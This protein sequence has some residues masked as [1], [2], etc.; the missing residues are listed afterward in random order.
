MKRIIAWLLVLLLLF[1]AAAAEEKSEEAPANRLT[2]GNPTPMRG[3]FFTSLWGNSTSDSDVRDLLHGYNLVIWDGDLG[4]FKTDPTVV[5]RISSRDEANGNRIYTVEL[6]HDLTYSD[7]T[8]ITAKDYAFTY[9]FTLSKEAAEIGA[10]ARR[11]DQFLGYEEYMSGEVPYL[12]GVQLINDYTL[13]ITILKTY[14]P[15]F[16]EYGLLLCN[17][18]P[19]SVIAPGVIVK[20]DGEGVYL[21]NEDEQVKDPIFTADLLRKTV[22][23]PETGY[24]SHP[25][26]VSG[27]YML[28]SWDGVTAEFEVNPYYKGNSEGIRPTIPSLVYT[29][30]NND[31]QVED[32]QSGT[33][34]LLNKVAR[35][36]VIDKGIQLTTS[37]N[38]A[39]ETY[40]RSGLCFL[41]FACEKSTVSSTAVRQAIAWCLDRDQLTSDYIGDYGVT[42]D[43]Y[44][45]IGQYMYRLV[46]GEAE[47]PVEDPE[48][49][50]SQREETYYQERIEAF[51]KLNLNGLTHY[52]V[53]T[54]KASQLLERDGWR[55][56]GDGLRE[57]NGVVLDLKMICPEGNN[58]T[59]YLEENFLKNL[60]TV[61]IRL[62]VEVVP[63]NQL[64]SY[65]YQQEERTADL[66]LLAS[67]FD[68]L[69]DPY[70]YF[71]KDGNWAYT[72]LQ[73]RALRFFAKSMITAEPGD[74]LTYMQNWVAFQERF[75]EILP[76]I[77]IYS[78]Y[79]YDFFTNALKNYEISENTTWSEA[80]VPA[81]LQ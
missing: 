66:I 18:Y 69:F 74:A 52:T 75:N 81:T 48:T 10:V 76:M 57:K 17:P 25:S 20:D 7:G 49:A 37:G 45:G 50:T 26:V 35:K 9:L 53:D 2:V 27:P 79:Y 15:F 4:A 24:Q 54:E 28:T 19:I 70:A 16:H 13:R 38:Y 30:S 67:N 65:W 39:M 56:N 51:K 40:T 1:S 64:L 60:E 73:D 78:N 59:D 80:I 62:T 68:L 46:T 72:C 42:V 44:Y 36:D 43:G 23:D 55:L 32:L 12:S 31:T 77:P 58:I 21:A 8:P 71:D 34:N 6:N 11:T 47:P 5:S 61:G 41:S 22:L 14:V 33:F 3:E 29:L 63:M